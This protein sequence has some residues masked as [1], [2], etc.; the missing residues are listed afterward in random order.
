LRRAGAEDCPVA[1]AEMHLLLIK[2]A[3]TPDTGDSTAAVKT[4]V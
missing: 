2:P 4:A 3:G 1:E